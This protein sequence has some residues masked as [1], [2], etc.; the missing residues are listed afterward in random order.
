MAP[1]ARFS[2]VHAA[3]IA[4]LALS[5]ALTSGCTVDGT[6]VRDASLDTTVSTT[7]TGAESSETGTTGPSSTTTS[8]ADADDITGTVWAG[9]DSDGGF[10]TF[11]FQSGGAL[12][13]TSPTGTWSAATWQQHGTAVYMEM[14]NRYAEYRGVIDGDTMRG[15]AGN[16]TGK[17]WT[18]SLTRR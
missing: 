1:T 15:S 4:G 8:R 13:Y 17:T 18:W 6:A 2:R 10:Y 14:N 3:L 11:R 9:T 7:T 16:I 12:N 5:T